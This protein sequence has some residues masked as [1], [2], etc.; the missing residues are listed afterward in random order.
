MTEE[1]RQEILANMKDKSIGSEK[2]AKAD[3]FKK[4]IIMTVSALAL[5]STLLT[6]CGHLPLK[7]ISQIQQMLEETDDFEQYVIDND[8]DLNEITLQQKIKII[9]LLEEYGLTEFTVERIKRHYEYTSEDYKQIKEL[10]DYYLSCFYKLADRESFDVMLKAMGY[11]DLDDFLLKNGYIDKNGKP[12]RQ[13]W[14]EEN[15]RRTFEMK[16]QGRQK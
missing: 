7:D 3:F 4:K 12:D 5:A 10:D 14:F 6:A 2:K 1:E 15:V 13:Q 16:E 8:I 11:S 9:A